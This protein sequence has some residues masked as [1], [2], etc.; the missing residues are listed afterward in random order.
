M[1]IVL[2]T[3]RGWPSWPPRTPVEKLQMGRSWGAL[4]VV[5]YVREL[6]RVAAKFFPGMVHWPS[7][8]V[9]VRM[10]AARRSGSML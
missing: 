5:I 9:W 2:L 10:A 3:T 7:S 4:D 8:G 6:K 1:Y